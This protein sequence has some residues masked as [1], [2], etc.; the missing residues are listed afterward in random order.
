MKPLLRSF[1]LWTCLPG[2]LFLIWTWQ[3][4]Q[5]QKTYLVGDLGT[6]TSVILCND[7]L[8]FAATFAK[9]PPRGSGFDIGMM[10]G[11]S[12]AGSRLPFWPDFSGPESIAEVLGWSAGFEHI[13]GLPGESKS[14]IHLARWCALLILLALWAGLFYWRYRR[15]KRI[16]LN[17]RSEPPT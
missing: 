2:L 7:D 9:H 16:S 13:D 15:F 17:P 5:K 4:A 12:E 3:D 6:R 1:T 10:R 11:P 14:T 8:G